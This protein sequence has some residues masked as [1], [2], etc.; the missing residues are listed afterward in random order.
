MVLYA[1]LL[2]EKNWGGS[3]TKQIDSECE[4]KNNV[5]VVEMNFFSHQMQV[6]MK[7]TF[8]NVM[9][10]YVVFDLLLCEHRI[11]LGGNI[12]CSY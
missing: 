12:N 3:R 2:S 4:K 6:K 9:S 5:K 7:V 11:Q 8:K 10:L 1:F